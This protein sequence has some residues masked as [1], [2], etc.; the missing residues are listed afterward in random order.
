MATRVTNELKVFAKN[1]RVLIVEDEDD[2]RNELSFIFSAPAVKASFPKIVWFFITSNS[3][4][5]RELGFKRILSGIATFP[6][7]CKGAEL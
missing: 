6:I 7:S 2:L 5:V 3:P 4:S 1:L